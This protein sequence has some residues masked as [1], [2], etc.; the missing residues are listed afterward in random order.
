MLICGSTR[1]VLEVT[2]VCSTAELTVI[3]LQAPRAK[4]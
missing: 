2:R 1:T 3:W 4:L